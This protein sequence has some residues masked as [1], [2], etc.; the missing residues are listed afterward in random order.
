MILW[1][2]CQ[3]LLLINILHARQNESDAW[4][5]VSCIKKGHNLPYAF[6]R[7]LLLAPLSKRPGLNM[8]VFGYCIFFKDS[9]TWQRNKLCYNNSLLKKLNHALCYCLSYTYCLSPIAARVVICNAWQVPCKHKSL[10]RFM[11]KFYVTIDLPNIAICAQDLRALTHINI[12]REW[13]STLTEV[14]L[15]LWCR[16]VI[17]CLWLWKI[18]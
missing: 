15:F 6:S 5:K 4:N 7:N 8:L 16:L 1:G 18:P 3:K 14:K 12:T 11:L 17:H 2:W 10:T 9:S 13:K